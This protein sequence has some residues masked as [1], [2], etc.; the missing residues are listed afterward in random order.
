[1]Q[2]PAISFTATTKPSTRA[3]TII[4]ESALR[5]TNRQRFANPYRWLIVA[6]GGA[7]LAWS[8]HSLPMP[9]LD[10]RFMLLAGVMVL[11]SSR[12]SVQVPRVNTNV[13]VSDTFIFLVMLLYGGL[14]GILV[15]AAEGLISGLRI[16]KKPLVIAFNSAM[17]ACSTFLTVTVMQS[18]F[19]PLTDL[20]SQDLS[21]F[22]AAIGALALTQYFSNTGL[23]AIVVAFKD[24]QP[25]CRT[26]HAKFL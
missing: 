7:A 2:R 21:H 22:I 15:A 17:M 18:L 23:S 10:L 4:V 16:S 9:R 24:N 12:F 11:V 3:E 8:G 13:T 6:S 5:L 14:A 20:S 26:W 25:I 1:M 19:G